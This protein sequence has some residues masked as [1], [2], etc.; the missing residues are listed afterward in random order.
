MVCSPSFCSSLLSSLIDWPHITAAGVVVAPATVNH[1]R[2]FGVGA[3]SHPRQ[4]SHRRWSVGQYSTSE[5]EREDLRA[6]YDRSAQS[7]PFRCC[8]SP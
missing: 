1:R 7:T 2:C 4:V 5:M 8:S 3:V 6:H